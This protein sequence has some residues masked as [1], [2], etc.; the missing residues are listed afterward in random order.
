MYV[1]VSCKCTQ[2]WP[3]GNAGRLVVAAFCCI[4]RQDNGEEREA[5]GLFC[6]ST[7]TQGWTAAASLRRAGDLGAWEGT[8]MEVHHQNVSRTWLQ[9]KPFSSHQRLFK[10]HVVINIMQICQFFFDIEG[11]MSA[12]C[13]KAISNHW[14][15][16]S[17]GM[18]SLICIWAVIAFCPLSCDCL[19]TRN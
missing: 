4:F 2:H 11:E 6:E 7:I 17:F 15:K 8:L 1:S 19:K 13:S 5:F 16:C 3:V 9:G 10:T 12:L 18:I 14:S